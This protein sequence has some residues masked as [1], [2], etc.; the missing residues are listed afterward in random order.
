MKVKIFI[1]GENLESKK[2][3]KLEYKNKI[4]MIQETTEHLKNIEVI[5]AELCFGTCEVYECEPTPKQNDNIRI[6]FEAWFYHDS[7]NSV[8]AYYKKGTNETTWNSLHWFSKKFCFFKKINE[9]EYCKLLSVN[10]PIWY[11]KKLGIDIE[12]LTLIK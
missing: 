4:N 2:E 10:A 8:G 6:T 5:G 1:D 12:K 7:K 9:N 11:L 3:V